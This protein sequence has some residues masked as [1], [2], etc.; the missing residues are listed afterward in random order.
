M[1]IEET[2][3]NSFIKELEKIQNDIDGIVK[4]ISTTKKTDND[5]WFNINKRIERQYEKLRDLTAKW[6]N[7]QFPKIYQD[8]L[9]KV[10][11]QIKYTTLPR[12]KQ[13][14]Y[15]QFINSDMS[16][17]TIR[18]IIYNTLNSYYKGYL[19]GENTLKEMANLT[20]IINLSEQKT[21]D[22]IAEG[23][24]EKGTAQRSYKL[25][26]DELLKLAQDGKYITIIDKNG[27]ERHYKPQTYAELVTRTKMQE[28][29]TQAVLNT[30][31]AIDSDLIQ[32]SAH[33]TKTRYD[34]QFE[35]KIFSLSGRD[36]DFPK[37]PDLP[38]FHVN[39]IHSITIVFREALIADGT[40]QKYIDFSNDES[41]G[42]PNN[43]A[44]I[45]IDKRGFAA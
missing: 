15:D 4:I 36:R 20:Q 37:A 35:G 28:A 24:E 41:S 11:T 26:K 12:I 34:A 30:A 44:F 3:F 10:L 5:F 39:C 18:D 33:N 13:I 22:I 42:M 21:R 43:K 16:K 23:I 38:P 19:D 2:T 25:L 9:N 17:Q 14:Q 40:L 6:V 1:T 29:N 31:G 27:K 32:V 45:P 7:D 8:E